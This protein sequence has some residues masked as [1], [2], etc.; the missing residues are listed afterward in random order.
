MRAAILLLLSLL[1]LAARPA[2]AQEQEG[3]LLKRIEAARPDSAKVFDLRQSMFGGKSASQT[4]KS[5]ATKDFQFDQKVRLKEYGT[6]G[7][8]GTKKSALGDAKFAAKSARTE[9]KYVIPNVDKRTGD[10]TASVKEAREAN[11]T[12][13]TRGLPDGKRP[14]LGRENDKARTPVDPA[15]AANWRG[16]SETVTGGSHDIVRAGRHALTP[17][18]RTSELKELS[19]DDVRDILNK[20]K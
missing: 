2:C 4:D 5:K 3:G 17:I 9:G 12:M 16:S 18:E 10:K 1:L 15:T 6:G 8:W 19:I 14:F 7:F 13:A 11:Q 20:N